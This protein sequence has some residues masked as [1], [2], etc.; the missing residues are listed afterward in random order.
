MSKYG[1]MGIFCM[2]IGEKPE[3]LKDY[4]KNQ[5]I[6]ETSHVPL[7]NANIMPNLLK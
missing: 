5:L 3:T 2:N 1:L 4:F 6:E 7:T